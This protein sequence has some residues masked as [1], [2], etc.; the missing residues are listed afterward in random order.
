MTQ[1]RSNSGP[2]QPVAGASVQHPEGHSLPCGEDAA[3]L[4]NGARLVETCVTERLAPTA[5]SMSTT[6][7]IH[8]SGEVTIRSSGTNL[9][10][11]VS[12]IGV[13]VLFYGGGSDPGWLWSTAPVG[14]GLEPTPGAVAEICVSFSQDVNREVLMSS[15]YVVV[16]QFLCPSRDAWTDIKPW[17]ATAQAPNGFAAVGRSVALLDDRA[18]YPSD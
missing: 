10:R 5:I 3:T 18:T 6:A 7:T 9:D 8:A 11:Q 13:V 15:K 14:Y 4:P 1:E 17:L 12:W 2:R 16:K